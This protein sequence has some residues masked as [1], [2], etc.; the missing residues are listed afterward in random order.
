MTSDS[1]LGKPR[2]DVLLRALLRKLH[3]AWATSHKEVALRR[4]FQPFPLEED[5]LGTPL[6]THHAHGLALDN[7]RLRVDARPRP[8]PE[9]VAYDLRQVSHELV[10][11]VELVDLD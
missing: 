11:V 4:R 10:V 6:A 1:E 9:A 5:R 7:L 8:I 3:G 2:S